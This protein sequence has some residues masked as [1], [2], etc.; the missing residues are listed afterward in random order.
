MD[1][2]QEMREKAVRYRR[3]AA[4]ITD[5]QAL[6][7]LHELAARYEAMAAELEEDPPSA[8]DAGSS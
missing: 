5:P 6:K 2:P 7:A 1:T 4:T 3:L 8:S